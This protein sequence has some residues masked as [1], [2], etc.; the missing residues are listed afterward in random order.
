MST[1]RTPFK[2]LPEVQEALQKGY[3]KVQKLAEIKPVR[4]QTI[5]SIMRHKEIV[6]VVE[7]LLEVSYLSET[8][9]SFMHSLFVERLGRTQAA[10]KA[11]GKKLGPQK[12]LIAQG[13]LNDKQVR[14]FVEMIQGFYQQLVP[15]AAI[16]ETEVLLDEHTK[17]ETRLLAAK[18]IK[19]SAGIGVQGQGAAALPVSITINIPTQTNITIPKE[20]R[21]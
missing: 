16:K 12:D 1:K 13:M 5:K 11:L 19:E 14:E 7:E 15:L 18:Q 9:R 6:E 2:K 10:Q 4:M 20:V 3:D 21:K 17:P 8:Q